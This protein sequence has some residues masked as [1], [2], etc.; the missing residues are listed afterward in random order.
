MTDQHS[1]DYPVL[2]RRSLRAIEEL[3]AK[4]AAA[5]RAHSEPIAVIG[6]GCRFPG[7]SDDPD[8][9]WAVLRDGVDTV[10]EVPADRWDVDQYYDPDPDAV[11]KSYTRWG[12]FIRNVSGFDAAFFGISPREAV[13]LDPQHRLLMEVTWEA[14]EHAGVA[15]TSLAGSLT[16]VYVGIGSHDYAL[17]LM[18]HGGGAVGDA[19]TGSGTSNSMAAGRLSYLLGLHGPAVAIDTACS[20]SLVAIHHAVA[21]LRSPR[22]RHGARRWC[23]P[24]AHSGRVGADVA[25]AHDVLRGALQDLRRL[26]GR[27]RAQRRLRHARAQAPVGR[28]ARR[29]SRARR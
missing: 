27:I 3:E 24:H 10:T 21:C 8:S 1:P 4:L 17:R 23:E 2:L 6:I 15:P 18:Q 16:A 28:P 26:G 20:S 5:E 22:G 13:S 12:G 29:R 25:R 9:F 7:D 11:G 14:L 19:Y